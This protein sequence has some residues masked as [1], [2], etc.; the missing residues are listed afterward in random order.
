MV[1]EIVQH[2]S[3]YRA[4][5]APLIATLV[6]R[7]QLVYAF[8]VDCALF[9]SNYTYLRK[10]VHAYEVYKDNG[11]HDTTHTVHTMHIAGLSARNRAK[12]DGIVWLSVRC[13][14][15]SRVVASCFV[16]MV[17]LMLESRVWRVGVVFMSVYIRHRYLYECKFE[18]VFAR[19]SNLRVRIANHCVI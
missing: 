5:C 9:I 12:R 13:D 3:S 18:R 7:E 2:I 10:K 11:L 6:F 1:F 14:S 8:G 15:S 19:V 4:R 16:V 17:M